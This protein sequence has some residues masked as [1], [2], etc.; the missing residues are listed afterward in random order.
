MVSAYHDTG[1]AIPQA[2]AP[3][4]LTKSTLAVVPPQCI[5]ISAILSLTMDEVMIKGTKY[6]SSK[7][8]ARLSGYAKDYIGQLVRKGKLRA[9]KVGRAWFVDEHELQ[10]L[11]STGTPRRETVTSE[12]SSVASR[13]AQLNPTQLYASVAVKFPATWSE[14]RYSVDDS[15][16]LPKLDSRDS[17][18][19]SLLL[20]DHAAAGELGRDRRS[21]STVK[22]V[23]KG[24]GR[25]VESFDGVRVLN[26]QSI[27]TGAGV[28]VGISSE[29]LRVSTEPHY[30]RLAGSMSTAGELLRL[31]AAALIVSVIL[32]FMPTLLG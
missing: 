5:L 27:T 14:V 11:S 21:I 28:G 29:P 18:E 16:L 12:S 3:D 25:Y 23:P 8:A 17:D 26:P 19:T 30:E 15:P 2:G 13:P 32:F 6:I 4:H 24:E 31:I 9:I 10:A 1:L 20:G 7:R 22:Y